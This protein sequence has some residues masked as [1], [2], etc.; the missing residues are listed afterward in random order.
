MRRGRHNDRSA[1][2]ANGRSRGSRHD[3]HGGWHRARSRDRAHEPVRVPN[4]DVMACTHPGSL[5]QSRFRIH[6][7][8]FRACGA[9]VRRAGNRYGLRAVAP[10]VR[11]SDR[12]RARAAGVLRAGALFPRFCYDRAC[13]SA[14]LHWSERGGMCRQTVPKGQ[15]G[16]R[17]F[18]LRILLELERSCLQAQQFVPSCRA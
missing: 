5:C 6:R 17:E 11:N 4:I 14:A 7:R 8:D 10:Y 12:E 1:D 18:Y 15:W 16:L 2:D 9:G 13:S 3:R